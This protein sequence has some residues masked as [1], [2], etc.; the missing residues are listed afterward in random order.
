MAKK[1]S[2]ADMLDKAIELIEESKKA[3]EMELRADVAAS[4]VDC[5]KLSHE[6]M[7]KQL[8]GPEDIENLQAFRAGM[9]FA[10]AMLANPDFDY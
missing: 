6:E 9:R 10:A 3:R 4:I 7:I 1:M 5:A 8:D 2:A